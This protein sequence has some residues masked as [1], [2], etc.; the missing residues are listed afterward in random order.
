MMTVADV[1]VDIPQPRFKICLDQGEQTLDIM[2]SLCTK[3]V[4][5]TISHGYGTKTVLLSCNL[6]DKFEMQQS[7]KRITVL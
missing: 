7:Y 5:T 1:T 6:C 3:D 4:Y 2:Y